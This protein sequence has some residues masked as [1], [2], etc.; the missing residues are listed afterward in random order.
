MWGVW[1]PFGAC[2]KSC[3]PGIFERS[4]SCDNPPPAHGGNDCVGK[5]TEQMNCQVKPCPSIG[6][7]YIFILYSLK[8][9]HP[10]KKV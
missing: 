9:V 1:D 3:G 7:N 10:F 2:S 6:K 8:K 5:K 4:R